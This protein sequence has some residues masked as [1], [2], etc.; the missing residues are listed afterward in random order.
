MY[1]M[2]SSGG[3][4][5]RNCSFEKCIVQ[6][7]YNFSVITSGSKPVLFADSSFNCRSSN[8]GGAIQHCIQYPLS[9]T[10]CLF[11]NCHTAKHGG[12]IFVL[13]TVASELSTINNTIGM[14]CSADLHGG[15][16]NS[17]YR[18]HFDMEK[19]NV[20][21]CCAATNCGGIYLNRYPCDITIQCCSFNSL[22]ESSCSSQLS[23]GCLLVGDGENVVITDCSFDQ[24]NGYAAGGINFA[25]DGSYGGDYSTIV[26]FCYF[27]GNFA[28]SGGKDI[29]FSGLWVGHAVSH[30]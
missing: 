20:T 2:I 22:K 1:G 27:K 15:F 29:S 21:N 17:D 3:F 30:C 8:D 5:T 10:G 7:A 18:K 6:H 23:S 24:C 12:A 4:E 25:G 11:F 28:S 16:V 9:I 13:K 14:N 19:T 26:M